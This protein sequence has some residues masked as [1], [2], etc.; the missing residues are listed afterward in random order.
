MSFGALSCSASKTLPLHS[1]CCGIVKLLK[2]GVLSV[3]LSSHIDSSAFTW[4]ILLASVPSKILL[5]VAMSFF[6]SFSCCSKVSSFAVPGSSVSLLSN[7][8]CFFTLPLSVIV[9]KPSI[10]FTAST[11]LLASFLFFVAAD[12]NFLTSFVNVAILVLPLAF[13]S[14]PCVVFRLV[15]ALV[16][17]PFSFLASL[18]NST[19]LAAICFVALASSTFPTL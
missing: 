14:L 3:L 1:S 17:A 6:F 19:S 15:S 2:V 11:A 7:S 16:A 18:F 9:L 12:F 8:L 4:F 13:F 5:A 10:S